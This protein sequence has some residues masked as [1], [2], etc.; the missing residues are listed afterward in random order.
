VEG[1]KIRNKSEGW[2]KIECE[3]FILLKVRRSLFGFKRMLNRC[4]ASLGQAK[5][6]RVLTVAP[7]L[8][9]DTAISNGNADAQRFLPKLGQNPTGPGP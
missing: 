1:L 9:V 7:Q 2:F 6:C 5:G 4:A 8:Q 3:I